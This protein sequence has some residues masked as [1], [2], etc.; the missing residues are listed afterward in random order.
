VSAVATGIQYAVLSCPGCDWIWPDSLPSFDEERIG[1]VLRE[2]LL[3][4]YGI[5]DADEESPAFRELREGVISRALRKDWP[6][7]PEGCNR[8]GRLLYLLTPIGD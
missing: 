7:C 3:P 6:R 1:R 8:R 5:E 2:S 4:E